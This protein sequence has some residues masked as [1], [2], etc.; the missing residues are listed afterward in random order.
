MPDPDID[1]RR[2][3]TLTVA[4]IAFTCLATLM[5]TWELGGS[6]ITR[7]QAG[8]WVGLA[9]HSLFAVIVAFLIYGGLVYQ[10]TRLAYHFRR[11]HHRPAPPWELEAIHDQDRVPALTILVPS[12]REEESTIVKTLLSAA[13]QEYP[14]CRIVLLI[15]DP[16]Q[17]S[18][19]GERAGL[20]AA[21]SLPQRVQDLLQ[22]P[23][24]RISAE[25]AAFEQRVRQGAL[26][27]VLERERVA[28][29]Y[30]EAAEW[31]EGQMQGHARSD[32]VDGFFV[33]QLLAA[34]QGRLRTSAA[35]IR[36]GVQDDRISLRRLYRRLAALFDAELTSF[37][38]KRY[39]N[40]SHEP[41]KAMNL[42]SYMGLVGRTW[43][44]QPASDGLHLEP[45]EMTGTRATDRSIPETDYFITLDAD[46][47]LMPDYALR[48]DPPDGT[49]RQPAHC[50]R[51]GTL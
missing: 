26:D 21:R 23:R 15:D 44:E 43:R 33:E 4:G 3:M 13:L 41:N 9:A 24:A 17:P 29:L 32:H 2:E 7:M 37:E 31:F 46:S 35:A 48:P 34:H 5:V 42:N 14:G 28:S 12:Y 38:R 50:R 51:S 40:L 8:D 16:P 49:A 18:T 30:D 45:V 47:I 25:L 10:L 27:P 6:W 11:S 39:V 20:A 19:P 36:E 1:S 22:Q